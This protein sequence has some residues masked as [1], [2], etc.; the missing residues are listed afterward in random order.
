MSGIFRSRLVVG[1][2]RKFPQTLTLVWRTVLRTDR[3]IIVIQ[4][5]SVKIRRWICAQRLGYRVWT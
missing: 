2:I 1:S 3:L 4:P 5:D